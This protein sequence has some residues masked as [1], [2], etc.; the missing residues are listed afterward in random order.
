MF[1]PEFLTYEEISVPR[2]TS[3]RSG[4]LPCV[5]RGGGDNA[6]MLAVRSGS[7]PCVKLFTDI[8]HSP[9]LALLFHKPMENSIFNTRNKRNAEQPVAPMPDAFTWVGVDSGSP[10]VQTYKA[11]V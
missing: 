2:P 3:Q 5:V 6:L 8:D 7:L 1:P 9:L 11:R 10:H 4:L